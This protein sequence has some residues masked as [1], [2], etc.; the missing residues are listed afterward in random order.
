MD[1]VERAQIDTHTTHTH[2]LKTCVEDKKRENNNEEE[3]QRTHDVIWRQ[4]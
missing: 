3:R 4:Y 2:I 1:K